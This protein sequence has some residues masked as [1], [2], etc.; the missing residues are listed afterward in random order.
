V[1]LPVAA[2]KRKNA[3]LYIVEVRRSES[4]G[5]ESQED[6]FQFFD[7]VLYRFPRPLI[8][9]LRQDQALHVLPHREGPPMPPRLDGRHEAHAAQMGIGIKALL[10]KGCLDLRYCLRNHPLLPVWLEMQAPRPDSGRSSQRVLKDGDK[11][12]LQKRQSPRCERLRDFRAA[13]SGQPD[14]G[15]FSGILPFP[16]VSGSTAGPMY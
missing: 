14:V 11:T 4:L 1:N 8:A 12:A 5:V 13:G 15:L 9:Q 3:P 2:A 6:G 16:S 10:S 7:I